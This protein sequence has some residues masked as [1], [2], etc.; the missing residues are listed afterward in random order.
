MRLFGLI[1]LV[2][3]LLPATETLGQ[4]PQE[5]KEKIQGTWKIVSFKQ[6]GGKDMAP[7]EALKTV[8]VVIAA[9]KIVFDFG[10]GAVDEFSYKLDSS[11]EPKAIDLVEKKGKPSLPGVYSLDGDDLKLCWDPNAKARPIEFST[12]GKATEKDVRLLVLKRE[13][14][15]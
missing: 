5:D 8:K 6:I 4:E 9:D 7:A 14:K 1:L 2:L 13:K 10:K 12:E 11:K 15:K 3:V